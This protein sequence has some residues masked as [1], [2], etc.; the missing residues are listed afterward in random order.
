MVRDKI[1]E[2]SARKES[3]NEPNTLLTL[4]NDSDLVVGVD[5]GKIVSPK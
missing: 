5:D 1:P 4:S 3:I 2:V